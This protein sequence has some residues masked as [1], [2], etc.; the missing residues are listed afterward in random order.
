[1]TENSTDAVCEVNSRIV[2][3][4][5]DP[6]KKELS[7]FGNGIVTLLQSPKARG[8][9]YLVAT[10]D[11]LLGAVY[12]L[13][14]S[15]C[16]VHPFVARS[17]PIEIQAV[18]KRA[19]DVAQG[20]IRTS[21]N[22]LAGFHFNSAL[23]RIAA[24]YHRGLKV[25]SQREKSDL[26]K[27]ALLKLVKPAFPNWEHGYLDDIWDEV[28]HLKHAA[29]GVFNSRTIKREGANAAIAELLHLFNLWVDADHH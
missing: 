24:T 6:K 20:T 26:K 7:D 17:G 19:E 23:F 1:M 2:L 10:L 21:G 4:P 25:V 16:T 15:Q 11:D 27:A 13:I 22:W 14:L 9:N 5:A 12:A 8:N 29:G 28:N 18:L 3:D